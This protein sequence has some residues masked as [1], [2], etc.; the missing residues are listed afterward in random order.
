M[1]EFFGI[2]AGGGMLLLIAALL[3]RFLLDAQAV[4]KE[5][6]RALVRVGEI[7][8]MALC[9][10]YLS[11]TL[12]R[13]ALF[14]DVESVG[15]IDKSFQLTYLHTLLGYLR[16]PEWYAP[17]SG[18]FAYLGHGLGRLL[19]GR[20]VLGGVLLSFLFTFAGA[21]LL[22]LRLRRLL[23]EK[24]AEDGIFL[25]FCLPGAVFLFLPGW[26]SM[27]FAL[28]GLCFYLAG[29]RLPRREFSCPPPLFSWV[30]A[31]CA[32]L[33]AAVVLCLAAGRFQ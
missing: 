12:M 15:E 1:G 6:A 22:F 14:G 8:L 16:Q 29:K 11:A 30:I 31:V 17:L 10:Y 25:L 13:S 19:F 24:T 26:P 32:M 21:C 27:A 4:K 3:L 23:H 9:L 33:S 20:Y 28:A 5:R 18:F 7:T 2:L